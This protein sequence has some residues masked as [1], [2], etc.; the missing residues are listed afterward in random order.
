MA[1]RVGGAVVSTVTAVALLAACSAGSGGAGS[2][3]GSTSATSSSVAPAS[4]PTVPLRDRLIK[5]FALTGQPDW[6]GH[7]SRYLY[8]RQDSG[9]IAAID[10]RTNRIAWRV[11]VAGEDTCQ[12]LGVG[13]GSLWTCATR[14]DADGDDLVRID[15]RTHRISKVL[16]VGKSHRQGRL[17]TGFGRVWV[18]TSSPDGSDLVGVDPR[19]GKA[20]P[21]IAL[22]MLAVELTIDEERVWA[23]GSFTGEVVGVD[24]RA[25]RVA[26]RV[27][28]LARVG[29][30]SIITVGAGHL[31]VSGDTSTVGIDRETGNVAV[32]VAQPTTGFGG[33]AT[34]DNAL[35]I[36]SD[37]PF[38]TRVDPATGQAV[39]RIVAPDLPNPGDALVAF[40][41][42]WASSN[43]QSTLVR[44]RLR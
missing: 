32:E 18:I 19:T 10:P 20:D 31:W 1:R 41:S 23:V 25:R 3:P 22:G 4:V 26:Q 42:L 29:G 15:L 40:G 2:P 11:R 35:W 13:F 30:P 9:E 17:V 16:H 34:A 24:P 37:H 27:S 21:P 38:L 12:G 14:A 36:H 43:N 39:E 7:D 28:G 44:L 8:V 33:L 6:L 5:R